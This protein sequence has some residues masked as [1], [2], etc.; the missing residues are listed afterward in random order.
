MVAGFPLRAAC[1]QTLD[2]R[3][4]MPVTREESP[5]VLMFPL[6]PGSWVLGS[7]RSEKMIGMWD[8]PALE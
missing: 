3:T 6:A 1:G 8:V 5:M 7:G 2:V 4:F